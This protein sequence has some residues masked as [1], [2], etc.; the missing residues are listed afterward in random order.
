MFLEMGFKLSNKTERDKS[1]F[2]VWNLL[3]MQLWIKD[4][5][6]L[7]ENALHDFRHQ[8]IQL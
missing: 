1:P 2:F 5:S 8:H 4:A 3:V 7:T 6:V